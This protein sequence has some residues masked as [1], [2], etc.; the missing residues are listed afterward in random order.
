MP[1]GRPCRAKELLRV[2][3]ALDRVG[4][5]FRWGGEVRGQAADPLDVKNRVG[6]QERNIPWPRH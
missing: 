5:G 6:F 3:H 2:R 1:D 4:T